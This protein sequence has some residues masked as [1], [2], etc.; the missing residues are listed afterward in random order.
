MPTT[1]YD[2][3]V[4]GAG[5]A[6]CTVAERLSRDPSVRVLVLEAGG[7][8]RSAVVKTPMLLQFVVTNPKYSWNYETEPQGHLNNRTLIWPRGKTLGG[9]SSINAMHYMR[10]APENYDEWERE[11]GAEGWNWKTALPAFKEVQHQ[12]RGASEHH[13][14][15]GPLWVSDI[16]PLHPATEDFFAAGEKLQYKRNAD[17][18]GASQEGFGPYQVTQK[19][20]ERCSASLAFLRPA[21]ERDTCDVLTGALVRRVVIENGRATGVDVDVNGER[22]VINARKEVIL[23]GGAINSPQTLLLSGIGPADELRA[24]GVSVEHDLP[25]VG[26][27]LQD[28]LDVTAQYWAKTG[29]TLGF[30]LKATPRNLY[31]FARYALRGDGPLTVNGVQGGAFIKSGYAGDLPDLQLAFIPAVYNPHG[32][33]VVWGHGVTLHVCQLYPKSRGEIALKSDDPNEHPAI[34]PNYGADPY[35]LDVLADGLEKARTLLDTPPLSDDFKSWRYPDPS[36]KTHADRVEHVRQYAETL[37]HPTSTCA[38]G[39]GELSVVDSRC[40][41]KGIDGLRVVDASVMPRL[42]GG[43]T[44]APTIMIATRAA[45][46]IAEDNA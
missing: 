24:V 26:K 19:G 33:D 22:R 16:D 17:F 4:C 18:N 37:Y 6:G 14:T 3:I 36:V 23:S 41:V 29:R 35:D 28:H 8:D 1:E 7:S 46:M 27:N 5:S 10:G 9:S 11:Y 12:T 39:S 34:Q 2:Y 31:Q 45:A 21:L 40:R 44:N 43:N 20:L 25:G 32:K 13:G 42:V 15:D 30:S 38:M